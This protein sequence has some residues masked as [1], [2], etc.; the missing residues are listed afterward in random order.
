MASLIPAESIG[1]HKKKG[2]IT[3]GKDSDFTIFD[4]KMQVKSVY[5]DAVEVY[6]EN[7]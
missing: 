5:I 6:G 3:I 7:Y 4:E 1:I 2:S